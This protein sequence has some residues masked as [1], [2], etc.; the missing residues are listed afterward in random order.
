MYFHVRFAVFEF[1]KTALQFLG[2]TPEAQYIVLGIIIFAAFF[3][4]IRIYI[5]KK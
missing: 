4:D 2:V 5:A 1:L 3:L